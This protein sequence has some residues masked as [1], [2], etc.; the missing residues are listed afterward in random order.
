MALQTANQFQL[1]P[2]LS[3]LGRGISQGLQIRGQFEQGQQQQAAA[4]QAAL[5][6][7]FRNVAQAA[8]EVQ[9]LP[10][11]NSKLNALK[12]RRAQLTQQGIPTQDT[13]EVIQLFESGQ[14]EQANALIG[15]AVQ[16][17]ERL[18]FIQPTAVPKAP[19]QTSQVKN[20]VAAGFT[21]GTEE[22]QSELLKTI[23]PSTTI[24][25]S[26][27]KEESKALARQRVAKFGDVQQAAEQATTLLENLDQLDT[28]D[29]ETGALEPA[30]IAIARV[31]E[32]FG[33]DAKDLANVT[34]AQAFNAVST[35]LVNDIL[36]AATGPQTDQDA[37]RA[38]Q[39]IAS[40]GDT[41]GAVTFKNNSLRSLALRQVEQRDFISAKLD[42][43]KNLTTA[44]K[45]WREF[46]RKTP[47]L[48]SVVK[49]PNGLPVFF[50]QFKQSAA[51]RRPGISDQEIIQAW[52]GAH[53]K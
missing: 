6:D 7:R 3:Q 43:D 40:L 41:P 4:E 30:K 14:S 24:I 51:Q 31:A 45:E 42:E 27:E 38:R 39:T 11:N 19:A 1:T 12:N 53:G 34:G 46:K 37:I 25:G 49:G 22:F 2:D 48:S 50:F 35:R 44:N 26:G 16:T 33:V 23:G 17:G 47:S 52:R 15:S 18:G 21:P 29:V 28:I 5:Q 20:L 36:N 13:D 9:S 32:G 10:D 8:V